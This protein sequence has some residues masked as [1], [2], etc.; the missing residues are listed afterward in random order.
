MERTLKKIAGLEG[1]GYRR[2][3]PFL[4]RYITVYSFLV[5]LTRSSGA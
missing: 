1:G 5:A 3:S 2:I 4:I